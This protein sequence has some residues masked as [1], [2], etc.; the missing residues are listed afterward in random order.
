MLSLARKS[1]TE[2]HDVRI[3]KYVGIV[4]IVKYVGIVRIVMMAT[5]RVVILG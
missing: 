2:G 1:P 4:R 3:V 5:T